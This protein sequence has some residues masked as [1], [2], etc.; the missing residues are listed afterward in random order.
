MAAPPP[1][2]ATSEPN[3][4]V[5]G[6]QAHAGRVPLGK[7]MAIAGICAVIPIVLTAVGAWITKST[8]AAAWFV[9]PA[10]TVVGAMIAAVVQAHGSRT[11]PAG[12]GAGAD[13]GTA[14]GASVPPRGTPLPIA[15]LAIV[16]VIGVGGW[17][18]ATGAR[19][20]YGWI[21]GNESGTE[22]LVTPA[23]GEASGVLLTVT[24]VSHTRHFTRVKV[25][26]RNR[27]S[28]SVSLPLFENC[29]LTSAS[30]TAIKADDFRS[31]W[32]TTLAPGTRQTGV[33]VFTGHMPDRAR[34]ASMSFPHVFTLGG[35]ALTVS[36]IR[37]RRV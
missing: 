21:T 2:V 27:G 37:L 8:G 20:A 23:R 28:Q 24:G 1:K 15:L 33:I 30:G 17:A 29:V 6:L 11:A 22:R 36:D 32:S 9:G 4:D 7:T 34:H 31:D 19:F 18:L 12:D 26:A 25:T 10:A 35:G 3:G 13:P 14:P 5:A 16:V